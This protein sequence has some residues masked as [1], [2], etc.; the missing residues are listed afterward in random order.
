[1]NEAWAEMCCPPAGELPASQL[2][3]AHT[4]PAWME[5]PFAVLLDC[6]RLLMIMSGVLGLLLA[7]AS[8]AISAILRQF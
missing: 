6:V 7:A 2:L 5:D 8:C 3:C 1:M 4:G